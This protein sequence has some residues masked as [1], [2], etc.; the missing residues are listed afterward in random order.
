MSIG[1]N[2]PYVKFLLSLSVGGPRGSQKSKNKPIISKFISIKGPKSVL[3]GGKAKFLDFYFHR[4]MRNKKLGNV[5]KNSGMRCLCS[6]LHGFMA[7][8]FMVYHGFKENV[9]SVQY[10]H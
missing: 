8:G 5:K 2:T 9:L 10:V 3:R 4:C 1:A 6:W 7:Q